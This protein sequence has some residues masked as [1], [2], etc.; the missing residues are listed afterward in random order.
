MSVFL[1]ARGELLHF[2]GS[3]IFFLFFASLT[4]WKT[5]QAAEGMTVYSSYNK[6]VN[7]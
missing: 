5:R 6:V 7:I 2:A 1:T 4:W 3:L